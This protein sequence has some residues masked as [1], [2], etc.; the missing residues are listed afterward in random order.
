MERHTGSILVILIRS[1]SGIQIIRKVQIRIRPK[2]GIQ[3]GHKE[4][5]KE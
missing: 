4:T 3:I 5:Y 2:L 1:K